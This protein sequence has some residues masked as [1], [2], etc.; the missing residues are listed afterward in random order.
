MSCEGNRH[1]FF[2]LVEQRIPGVDAETLERIYQAAR[3]A[4]EDEGA[5][6]EAI[7]K[8]RL[9]FSD[10]LEVGITPPTH[11]PDGL[12]KKS[13]RRGYAA[14]YD[15][16]RN[17]KMPPGFTRDEM[18][19]LGEEYRQ[20]TGYVMDSA[21]DEMEY[22]NHA[23]FFGHREIVNGEDVCI[24]NGSAFRTTFL[25]DEQH[26]VLYP[27]D[28]EGLLRFMQTLDDHG[29]LADGYDL[30]GFDMQGLDARKR[31]RYGLSEEELRD[32]NLLRRLAGRKLKEFVTRPGR[33]TSKEI[34]VDLEGFGEDGFRP[35]NG[36][37]ETEVDRLGYNRT[38]FKNG[39]TFTGYDE[40][41]LDE[42][43]K[44][45]PRRTGYDRFGYE[46][47]TGLTAPDG[48]GRRYNLIGWVY[49]P[50]TDTCYNP[51][52]PSQRMPHR[53]SFAY[54]ARHQKVVLKRSY[55][56]TEDELVERLKN[57]EIRMKEVRAGGPPLWHYAAHS[58][59]SR[60]NILFEA[61]P[62]Y[63]YLTSKERADAH[64]EAHF[65]GVRLRCP[66]CGQFTGARPHSCPQY[67]GKNILALQNGM[68][69]ALYPKEEGSGVEELLTVSSRPQSIHEF[70]YR[71]IFRQNFQAIISSNGAEISLGLFP[72]LIQSNFH[73]LDRNA[74]K[75]WEHYY[76]A[77]GM[78]GITFVDEAALMESFPW[79]RETSTA[80]VLETPFTPLERYNPEYH[81]GTIAGFHWKSGLSEDGYDVWGF[82][83]LSGRH[84]KARVTRE[85]L[86]VR[87]KILE[88]QKDLVREM[89]KY[90]MNNLKELLQ[91]T[92]SRI[93]T[94]I[95]GSPRRV[96]I[97]EEGGPRPGMFWTDM[98]GT[99]QAEMNPLSNTNHNT[100]EANLLAFKAGIY[101]ELG[102]EEDTPIGIFEQVIAIASGEEEVDGIPRESAGLVAEIYNILED[103]RMERQQARHRRGVAAILAADALL[104][105]R[106][107]EKVGEDV[108]VLHQVMGMM[109]YR[110]LPF[111]RV[112]REVYE[113]A[114]ERVRKIFD[115]VLP[116][117]DHAMNGP[118]EAFAASIAIT[119]RLLQ[120]SEFRDL[121]RQMTQHKSQ[122][123]EWAS[124]GGKSNGL[125]ISA[126]PRP[127]KGMPSRAERLA[128]PPENWKP[129]DPLPGKMKEPLEGKSGR[130]VGKGG[131]EEESPGRPEGTG[132][133]EE[134]ESSG[135]PAGRGLEERDRSEEHGSSTLL[136]EIDEEFFRGISVEQGLVENVV[137][138]VLGDLRRGARLAAQPVG[139][140]MLKP[141][142]ETLE[143][144]LSPESEEERETTVVHITRVAKADGNAGVFARQIREAARKEG[145]RLSRRLSAL[146]QEVRQKVRYQMEGIPDRR[147]YK[148]AVTGSETVYRRERLVDM[149]SLAVGIQVDMS[150]SMTDEIQSGRL[151]GVTAVIEEALQ[152]L[153]A[154][155][156]VTAFG[157]TTTVVK[158]L[159]DEKISDESLYALA[160][161][162]LGGTEP[163]TAMKL[164]LHT[165]R[166]TKSTNK[167]H[168]L[169]TDGEFFYRDT[170]QIAKQMRQNGIMPFGLYL[171]SSLSPNIKMAFDNI[172]GEGNWTHIR[173][174]SD[175]AD[176]VGK[177]IEQIYRR[178]LATW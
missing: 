125:I 44:P 176:V 70:I 56:P 163:E 129:G 172:F 1:R 148:R 33:K 13:A 81:G 128:P 99:I 175:M 82:H 132:I 150:G 178:V 67:G 103:G 144:N 77:S 23:G 147:R 112:R 105:P 162:D 28:R 54:S 152:H 21:W 65:L 177:R 78:G 173:Q 165:F 43:G 18:M 71:K 2:S 16:L 118:E 136:P 158:T 149:T 107:D 59:R 94:G 45:A 156:F 160:H 72:G 7:R 123:G 113:A 30:T 101:H 115:E 36:P 167:L 9:L 151:A 155:Y 50:K 10:M 41:G 85:G 141:S 79:N 131:E 166:E 73:N 83:Y 25:G 57:P 164:S 116:Y 110:S 19:S 171:G 96:Q 93:A 76:T 24:G 15:A 37:E 126:L 87:G 49:D 98:K 52:D 170:A 75:V 161:T 3:N 122:G 84:K 61:S 124:K 91:R 143:I 88:Q 39:R 46:R 40:T 5:D 106:W 111:F 89:G 145:L 17:R 104:N 127:G 133:N 11:S 42:K 47:S 102:H 80:V 135:R 38:G 153:E 140:Q 48:Q 20:I 174:L 100:P 139:R 32:E 58:G 64:P 69:I 92:Y 108:P 74:R 119:R 134:D 138:D 63:R 95:A 8:T 137:L 55:V 114:P 14:V 157:T 146:R 35:Q 31:N 51:E 97:S 120:E 109:L 121:G 53:G 26:P 66:R 34:A 22:R 86:R 154:E 168:F 29:Q 27:D 62:I 90:G 130:P 142:S 60:A 6:E 169:L 159:G 4:P 117:V 68:V 12:P